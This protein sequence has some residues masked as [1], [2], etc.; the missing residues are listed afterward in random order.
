MLYG[1]IILNVSTIFIHYNGPSISLWQIGVILRTYDI[2]IRKNIS[3]GKNVR[4]MENVP[5]RSVPVWNFNDAMV[6]TSNEIYCPLN[7][8]CHCQ[9]HYSV[10]IISA[11]AS[12][13]AGIMIVYSNVCTGADQRKYQ[14]SASLTFLRG[15]YRW[16]VNSPH[17]GTV[18]RKMFPSDDVII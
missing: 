7:R 8:W 17:K 1:L 16:T 15:I 5:V 11:T 13:N 6:S 3:Y 4:Y 14:S 18:T 10:V 12:Q 2:N 9:S